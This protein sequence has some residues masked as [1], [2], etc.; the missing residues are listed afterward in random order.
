MLAGIQLLHFTYKSALVYKVTHVYTR[1][2]HSSQVHLTVTG[3]G[4]L[5][6]ILQLWLFVLVT[7]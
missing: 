5:S 7:C 3:L 6:C 2:Q 4:G 1:W